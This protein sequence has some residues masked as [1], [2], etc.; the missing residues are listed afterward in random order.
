MLRV[1]L[2]VFSLLCC[3]SLMAEDIFNG[4]DLTGWKGLS[5]YWSVKDGTLVGTTRPKGINF[6]TFLCSDKEYGDFE[7]KLKVKIVNAVGNS[8][9]QIRSKIDDKTKYVVA[10]PQCDMGQQYWGSL[11]GERFGGMMKASDAATVKK[12]VKPSD[13]N[14]YHI[15][16]QGKHVTIKING[17]TMVDGNFEKM[18]DKGILAFQI[19][20]GPAMDVIFKDI[21][22]TE[23]K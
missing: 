10:G 12:V 1:G 16:C 5:E 19:H 17:T 9:I 8:G 14:D 18:P 21:V 22:F 6:N 11:Y 3:S 23:L 15:V 20:G 7:L 13:F 4:K 2:T